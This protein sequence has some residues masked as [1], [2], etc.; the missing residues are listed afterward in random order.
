MRLKSPEK[1]VHGI[2]ELQVL[3]SVFTRAGILYF[4]AVHITHQLRA[5][6]DAEYRQP[7]ADV[8]QVHM[9]RVILIDTQGRTA[10]D[11]TDNIFVVLGVF[12][13]RQNLA[14]RVQFA[15]APTN[16]LRRLTAE[17]QDDDLLH[18]LGLIAV[19]N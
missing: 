15:Y 14:E 4:A 6:A 10:Q 18:S 19:N 13:I 8:T 7:S 9:K 2:N 16:Q 5:V 17:I 3:A 11:D 1:R 12:V